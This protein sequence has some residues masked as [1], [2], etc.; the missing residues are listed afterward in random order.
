MEV[1]LI[2]LSL[3]ATGAV[4]PGPCTFLT[5]A[6]IL[7]VQKATV[8]SRK[9]SAADGKNVEIRRCYFETD[10][11]SKSVSLEWTRDR[12]PEGARRQW[13]RLF[14]PE[15]DVHRD[16]AEKDEREEKGER[17]ERRAATPGPVSGVGEEAY[18]V[19]SRASG[20]I[21]AFAS[22]AFVRV[23]V[24][25]EGTDAEKKERATALARSA[26]AAAAAP[27]QESTPR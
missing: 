23:S 8:V 14:H 24:G 3:L 13:E 20:A 17:E 27:K 2:V 1:T 4:A 9:E 16:D 5:P 18:W 26:I 21:Y 22:H 6:D 10:P 19:P 7:A 11:N 25:G 12:V 15:R